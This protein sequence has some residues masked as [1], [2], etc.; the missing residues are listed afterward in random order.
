MAN[1]STRERA[2]SANYQMIC[3][4]KCRRRV[5]VNSFDMRLT[6][7]SEFGWLRRLPSHWARPWIVSAVGD[8]PLAVGGGYVENQKLVA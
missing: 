6:E 7:I 4:R 3:C 8:A 2:D 1:H 5:P